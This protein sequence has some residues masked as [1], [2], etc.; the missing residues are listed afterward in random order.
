MTGCD[1]MLRLLT[2][3]PVRLLTSQWFLTLMVP[4]RIKFGRQN[5]RG[6]YLYTL[7]RHQLQVQSN[8]SQ[9]P[10]STQSFDFSFASSL[11]VV[12]AACPHLRQ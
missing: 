3:C 12:S 2:W 10:P 5:W 8:E 7:T 11:N 9:R 1:V 4:S 6:V